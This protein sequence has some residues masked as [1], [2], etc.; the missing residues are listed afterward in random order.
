MWTPICSIAVIMIY[1]SRFYIVCSGYFRL[2]V[3]TWGILL[4]YIRRRLSLRLRFHV[5]WEAECDNWLHCKC[6]LC[7]SLNRVI[8]CTNVYVSS[9]VRVGA[10]SP[11][12]IMIV[13]VITLRIRMGSIRSSYI[14]SSRGIG[15]DKPSC[16]SLS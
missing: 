2:S 13:S 10:V 4:E 5:F 1:Y 3:Y 9:F 12:A 15:D 14:L 6:G 16:K 7:Q 11:A 8:F